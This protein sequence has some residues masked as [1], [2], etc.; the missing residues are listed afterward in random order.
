MM[1]RAAKNQYYG[2]IQLEMK[3]FMHELSQNPADFFTLTHLFCARISSR[4]AYGTSDRATEHMTNAEV[5]ISQLGPSGPIPNLM[6]F[7]R[8][9]PE[10]MAPGQRGVRERREREAALWKD[11]FERAKASKD[12][13]NY[14][15]ASLATKALGSET[16]LLFTNEEEAKAAVG[17]L[18]TVAIY[19]I[20]GPATLFIMA[21]ILHPEWQ[22]KV[23]QQID[24]VVGKDE[25]VDLE[26][27]P[28]L[29]ILRA[30]IKECVRWKSTVPLGKLLL[31]SIPAVLDPDRIACSMKLSS[32]QECLVSLQKTTPILT[33]I[34]LVVPSFTCSTSLSPNP[35]PH[36][37]PPIPPS[38]TPPAGSIPRPQISGLHS[39]NT[40]A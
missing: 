31:P 8:Y 19:T 12:T 13:T 40:H 16:D 7:L 20:G 32:G 27:S 28:H 36:T 18:C 23:R 22:E 35:L 1:T 37:P 15:T 17:M 6:P 5:F 11:M 3:R 39:R 34:S 10:W 4:L 21:M 33:T 14:T 24:E 26:H 25:M 2:H 29:P 38:T 9:F 30:A